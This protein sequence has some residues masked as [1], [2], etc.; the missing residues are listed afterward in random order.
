MPLIAEMV[1][2]MIEA[3][4]APDMIALAVST[5]EQ[6][7]SDDIV[8][9]GRQSDDKLERRRAYDRKR[10]QK[11]RDEVKNN[12]TTRTTSDDTPSS[13]SSSSSPL[14]LPLITTPS[15]PSSL[16]SLRE[17]LIKRV[18]KH[19][20]PADFFEQFWNVYPRKAAKKNA[21]R[22][23]EK[24]RLSDEVDFAALLVAIRTIETKDPQFIPHP[25]TWL[26]RGSYL[27]TP[28]PKVN[29]RAEI[30]ALE[31]RMLSERRGAAK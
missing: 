13:T 11:I 19:D 12:R 30:D 9:L 20:W 26:N 5:C 7:A 24:V 18:F 2:Q 17:R 16:R 4:V 15:S 8:R 6:I 27:D 10:Q 14:T 21:L 28:A 22:A 3:G 25:A 29:R 1:R 23:L 31:E